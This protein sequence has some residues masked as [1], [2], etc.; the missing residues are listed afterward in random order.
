MKTVRKNFFLL[1]L[2]NSTIPKLSNLILNILKCRNVTK[3]KNTDVAKTDK[4]LNPK[5]GKIIINE[6]IGVSIM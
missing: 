5:I 1:K 2:P 6:I 4:K 3:P